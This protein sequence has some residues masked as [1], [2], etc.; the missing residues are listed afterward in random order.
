MKFQKKVFRMSLKF[1]WLEFKFYLLLL[2][3]DHFCR[4]IFCRSQP[5]HAVEGNHHRFQIRQFQ[6]IDG[7]RTENLLQ[8][9]L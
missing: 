2:L 5:V 8:N 3:R 6:I 9:L 1:V 4:Q 7:D